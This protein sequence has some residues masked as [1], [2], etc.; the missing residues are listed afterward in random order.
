MKATKVTNYF[1]LVFGFDIAFGL[2]GRSQVK[3]MLC[4]NQDQSINV[5]VEVI[6]SCKPVWLKD[7]GPASTGDSK[8]LLS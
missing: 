4:S 2:L 8:R 3:D 1:G 5:Y 7:K 6:L